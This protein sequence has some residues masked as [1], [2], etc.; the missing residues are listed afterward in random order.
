MI[1]LHQV[2]PKDEYALALLSGYIKERTHPDYPNYTIV[3]YT[4]E[5]AWTNAW[6]T[7][8]LN[9]RGLIFDSQ[10]LEVIARPF[11]KFFN[12]EQPGAPVWSLETKVQVLDKLDGSLGILYQ[13]PNGEYAISTR[14]SFTSEQ[15]IWA[16]EHYRA[17]C[18][19]GW[20]PNPDLTY[21]Y[22]IIYPENRIVVDYDG[23]ATLALL[24]AVNKETG[25]SISPLELTEWVGTVVLVFSPS[26]TLGEVLTLSPRKNREGFVLH[27]L[28]TDERV[29]IKYDDYK[30]L[31]K[32]LTSTTPKNIWEVLMQGQSPE[33]VFADA[34]DEFH[35]WIKVIID[36]LLNQFN[37]IKLEANQDFMTVMSTMEDLTNRKE[38]ALKAK[39]F[40]TT[41]CL[42]PLF[43]SRPIDEIIWKKI[44]PRGD[45][46]EQK[47]FHAVNPE[48]D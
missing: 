31:H 48:A 42:F 2:I 19:V 6:S 5:T 47:V 44:K 22:E 3:N 12:Y 35:A 8:T 7:A 28:T 34:P 32:L 41:S 46:K 38:F 40:P 26:S 39:E 45:D 29:K 9:S 17:H 1:K 10:T 33:E 15:A 21:L 36:G 24:G 20:E 27:N 16:T 13:L 25:V 11:S 37:T 43:D 14:G 18:S 30:R 4:P 23:W